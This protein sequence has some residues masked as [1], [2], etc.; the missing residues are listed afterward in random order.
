VERHGF[1][2][3]YEDALLRV[4]REQ[5]AARDELLGAR[6][7]FARLRQALLDAV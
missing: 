2:E 3:R 1:L 6:R 4:L 5:A 7:L